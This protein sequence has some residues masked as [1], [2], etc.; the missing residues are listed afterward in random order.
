MHLFGAKHQKEHLP[1]VNHMPKTVA[2]NYKPGVVQSS[3][4]AVG[5]RDL[6]EV[7]RGIQGISGNPIAQESL[8]YG[9]GKG[10]PVRNPDHFSIPK[11]KSLQEVN[12]MDAGNYYNFKK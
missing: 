3:S 1:F 4:F 10:L 12:N 9:W 7:N 11:G 8:M 6:I 5:T 2:H